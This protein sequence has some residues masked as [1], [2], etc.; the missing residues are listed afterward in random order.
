[1]RM[2]DIDGV[3]ILETGGR[4]GR[5]GREAQLV[6]VCQDPRHVD[7]GA[8]ELGGGVWREASEVCA[9]WVRNGNRSS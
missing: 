2:R 5:D 4:G 9:G 7:L 6:V 8:V 1:L 3:G